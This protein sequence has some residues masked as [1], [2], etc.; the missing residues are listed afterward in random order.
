MAWIRTVSPSAAAGLLK[1]L[2]DVAIGRAGRV[3]HVIR[4]MSLNPSVLRSSMELYLDLM[5]RRSS[6]SRSQR[7]MIAT[8]VSRVNNCYY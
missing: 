6:L 8:V 5:H 1:T 2:Y 3:F 4:L 7:E